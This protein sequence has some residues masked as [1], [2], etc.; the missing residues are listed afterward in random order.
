MIVEYE[1]D[2]IV[3]NNN[4]EAHGEKIQIPEEQDANQFMNF[5]QMH[6]NLRDHRV[7]AQLHNNLME[8]M[9]THNGNQ[10]TNA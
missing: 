7:H 9:W 3:Q 4:F 2:G 1:D 6:H 8:H 5:L 10:W